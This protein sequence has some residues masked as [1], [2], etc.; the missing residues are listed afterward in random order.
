MLQSRQPL[1]DQN[2]FISL[3]I[4]DN[5]IITKILLIS[6]VFGKK[7]LFKLRYNAIKDLSLVK[8]PSPELFLYNNWWVHW[9]ISSNND[10]Q[11]LQ[12][13]NDHREIKI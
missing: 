11:M 8:Y 7:K 6:I 5:T 13:Y 2:H 3:K 12:D 10:G 9:S 1:N 4:S